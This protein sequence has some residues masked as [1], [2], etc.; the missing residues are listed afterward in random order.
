MKAI[1]SRKSF[2]AL[3]CSSIMLA[4][5]AFAQTDKSS[6]V[7][8]DD[9]PIARELKVPIYKWVDSTKPTQAVVVALHG[10]T[11]HGGAFDTIARSLAARGFPVYAPDFRGFGRW[12]MGKGK[13]MPDGEIAYYKSREDVV[14]LLLKLREENK[15]MPIV[16]MGESLGANMAFWLASVHPDLLDG[17]IAAS[18]CSERRST[19]C[20]TLV[21]DFAKF[22][23]RPKRSIPLEPYAKR[24]LSEDDKIIEAYL[25]D[26]GNRKTMTFWETM[27]SF[28]A[29]KSSLMFVEQIPVNMP[30]LCILGEQD[31]MYKSKAAIQ[32]IL[33]RIPSHFED[34]VWYKD[35]GHIHLET[36][37]IKPDIVDS[38]THWIEQV[39]IT[40]TAKNLDSNQAQIKV[41]G[42]KL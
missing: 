31:R 12:Y 40:Q 39:A 33:D 20:P 17:I 7:R 5:P 16:L 23:V 9:P 3:I 32:K 8:Y 6:V 15:N 27:Q 11:L 24:F 13:T 14:T 35:R 42:T 2:A 41:T 22:W 26:P 36:P 18:P 38:V 37:H 25:E 1:T 34:V 4:A 29:N 19:L 28:H 10:A 30:I 21:A